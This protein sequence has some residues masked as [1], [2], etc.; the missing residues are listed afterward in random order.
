MDNIFS[1]IIVAVVTAI[2]SVLGT[3]YIQRRKNESNTKKSAL[4][5]YLNLKQTK[6][7][8]DKDKKGIDGAGEIDIMPMNYFNPF[9]YIGILC[10]LKER[11][12]EH[13]IEVVNNFYDNVK[14]LDWKKMN[15]FNARG[16]NNN[17]PSMNPAFP[18]IYE[19]QYRDSCTSYVDSLNSI[20]NNDEYKKDIVEII[21]KLQKMKGK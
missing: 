16:L 12:S 10:D 13:E 5:L 17:F 21:S 18:G 15:L 6:A 7:D 11:L 19:Q 4:Y 20:T 1:S 2:L 8:I 3:L 9:N 14:K